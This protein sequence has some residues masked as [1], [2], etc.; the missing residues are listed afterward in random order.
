MSPGFPI[1]ESTAA[2]R[3]WSAFMADPDIDV[4]ELSKNGFSEIPRMSIHETILPSGISIGIDGIFPVMAIRDNARR[5]LLI[6]D[7]HIALFGE[8][9]KRIET[10]APGLSVWGVAGAINNPRVERIGTI[11]GFETESHESLRIHANTNSIYSVG[12]VENLSSCNIQIAACNSDYS[13]V[14]LGGIPVKSSRQK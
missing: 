4:H 3:M 2:E 7:R 14:R 5:L 8:N 10:L 11:R 12:T 9:E 6:G 1:G 13:Q